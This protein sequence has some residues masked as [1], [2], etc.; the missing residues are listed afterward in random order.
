MFYALSEGCGLFNNDKELVVDFERAGFNVF[1][2]KFDSVLVELCI[3]Y[4]GVF[5]HYV[6]KICEIVIV[7]CYGYEVWQ[8]L[9]R[10][11]FQRLLR[12]FVEMHFADGSSGIIIWLSQNIMRVKV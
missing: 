11:L 8:W 5:L 9:V 7:K 3:F 4:I 12:Y 6:Y 10:Y 1:V 2:V